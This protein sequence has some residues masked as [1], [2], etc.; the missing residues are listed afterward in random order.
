L[1]F[2]STKGHIGAASAVGVLVFI[3]TSVVALSIFYFLREKE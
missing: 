3:M 2:S 1:K